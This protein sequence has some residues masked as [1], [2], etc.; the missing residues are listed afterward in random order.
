VITSS[1]VKRVKVLG[2]QLEIHEAG[3]CRIHGEDLHAGFIHRDIAI[4]NDLFEYFYYGLKNTPL[5][6]F[7][8]EEDHD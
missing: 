2:F 5:N 7:A 4:M 1:A 6:G 3:M 8:L